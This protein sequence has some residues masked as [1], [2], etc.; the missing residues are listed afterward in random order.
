ME[1]EEGFI[2]DNGLSAEQVTAINTNN[3]A[4]FDTLSSKANV[5]AEKILQGAAQYANSAA[6]LDLKR[7]QG[8]K[9]GDYLNRI[10][11]QSMSSRSEKIAAQETEWSEKIK[12]FKGNEALQGEYNSLKEQSDVF[13]RKAV[14]FDEWSAA[15]YKDK[16]ESSSKELVSLKQTIAFGGAKPNFPDSVNKYEA[17]AKWREFKAGFLDKYTLHLDEYGNA[18]GKAKD[19][20]FDIVKLSDLVGKDATLTGLLKGTSGGLST[21]PAKEKKIDGVPFAV[22]EGMTSQDITQ[23]V[24]DYLV[25]ERKL[26]EFSDEF[27]SE[28]Q[29]YYA[30]VKQGKTPK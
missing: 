29:K 14:E 11:D 1:L 17:D 9:Y 12:N 28:F 20:E 16:A 3:K 25:G 8:E 27:A 2:K 24:T 15:G 21:A 6:G 19:N 23:K 13:K 18:I 4:S 5:D 22:S 26:N 10:G 7:D 30:L